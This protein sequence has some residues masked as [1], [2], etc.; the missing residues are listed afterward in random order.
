MVH[1]TLRIQGFRFNDTHDYTLF[2]MLI[3][4]LCNKAGYKADDAHDAH[5]DTSQKN[6]KLGKIYE[7]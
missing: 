1:T 5:F 4:N 2:I 7:R 3:H 6:L